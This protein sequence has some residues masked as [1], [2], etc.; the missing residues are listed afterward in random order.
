[1]AQIPLA[2]TLE[3]HASFDNFV[4]GRNRAAMEHLR[5]IACDGRPESIWLSGAGGTGKSHLLTAG[6]RAATEAGARAM[7]ITL[8]PDADP[9]MLGG[10]DGIAVL[11]LDDLQRV[12]GRA[13]WERAL[14]V[15][16]DA[17][18]QRG[19][20]L[21]AASD[22]PQDCGFELPDLVSR[23][24]AAAGYRL[25]PL[26]DEELALAITRQAATRGLDLD[27]A[28]ANYLLQRLRRDL[29]ELSAWLDRIDQA[30]LA[31]QRRITI[32]LLR[33]II[34]SVPVEA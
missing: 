7:L 18:L 3:S 29:G 13:D 21:L 16:L 6:C 1:M 26:D 27:E 9:A 14:F 12:A 25:A 11:A 31:R 33:E 19:G 20:L 8:T 32:P 17:R 15:V 10:L 2:L 28:A 23:A 22:R 5:G 30:A 24:S 4:P 34:E